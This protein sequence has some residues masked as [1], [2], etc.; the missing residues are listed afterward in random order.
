M[1]PE[2]CSLDILVSVCARSFDTVRATE[3]LGATAGTQQAI[4]LDDQFSG[5]DIFSNTIRNA[6]VGVMLSGGRRN[7]IHENYFENCVEQDIYFAD[8]VRRQTSC[9]G[10]EVIHSLS[11]SVTQSLSHSLNQP[12]LTAVAETWRP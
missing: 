3:T 2:F 12:P 4:Y 1:F 11:H 8:Q 5:V 10:L 7:L 6:T 9:T